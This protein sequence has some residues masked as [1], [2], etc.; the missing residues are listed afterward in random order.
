MLQLLMWVVWSQSLVAGVKRELSEPSMELHQFL[1]PGH[2]ITD[3]VASARRLAVDLAGRQ[4]SGP[5]LEISQ[6]PHERLSHVEAAS[7]RVLWGQNRKDHGWVQ[8]TQNSVYWTLLSHHSH[9]VCV[10]FNWAHVG[11]EQVIVLR[12]HSE[13]VHVLIMLRMNIYQLN[14]IKIRSRRLQRSL[15]KLLEK[16]YS[17]WNLNSPSFIV[18][19]WIPAGWCVFCWALESFLF[20]L[21]W[22][23][24]KPPWPD[25][26]KNTWIRSRFLVRYNYFFI[27]ICNSM[28][29]LLMFG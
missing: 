3:E 17:G 22:I 29:H 15:N 19:F 12:I 28:N 21:G 13:Q 18:Y 24:F 20:F 16:V 4:D 8:L 5:E 10:M 26:A 9:K 14:S 1:R 23:L 6:L 27:D 7:H 11:V 25:P 2:D